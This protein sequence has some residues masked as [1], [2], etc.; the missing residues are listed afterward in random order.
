M[1][2]HRDQ[3]IAKMVEAG[4]QRRG[5][6]SA[7]RKQLQQYLDEAWEAEVAELG[8]EAGEK[9]EV[10]EPPIQPRPTAWRRVE[11][12]DQN[13][14]V[15][16]IFEC[17]EPSTATVSEDKLI[18]YA[19]LWF[20]FDSMDELIALELYKMD[21][22]GDLHKVDLKELFFSRLGD[23]AAV[24]EELLGCVDDDSMFEAADPDRRSTPGA[25][26]RRAAWENLREDVEQLRAAARERQTLAEQSGDIRVQGLRMAEVE[27]F[28]AVLEAMER[29][30]SEQRS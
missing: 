16:V 4:F 17:V 9:L 8:D 14:E 19:E 18:R 27:A 1:R 13:D 22:Y 29:R 20:D 7:L 26:V 25:A 2:T 3:I 5:F 10:D 12:K 6:R 30:N 24:A 23:R 21:E 28:D 15:W 11:Q